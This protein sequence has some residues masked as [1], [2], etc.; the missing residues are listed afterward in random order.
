MLASARRTLVAYV[1]AVYPDTQ[2]RERAL[3]E[4]EKTLARAASLHLKGPQ[5]DARLSKV[6]R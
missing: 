3:R 2:A 5:G 4:L 6:G 1:F